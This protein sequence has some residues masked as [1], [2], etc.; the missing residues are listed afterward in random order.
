MYVDDKYPSAIVLQVLEGLTTASQ[1]EA[2]A[3]ALPSSP[4]AEGPSHSASVSDLHQGE[5]YVIELAASTGV[6]RLQGRVDQ[7]EPPGIVLSF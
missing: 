6:F 1:R 7:Q 5:R 2:L 4:S 3:Q